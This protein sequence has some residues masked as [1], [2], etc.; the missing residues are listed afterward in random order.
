MNALPAKN[1]HDSRTD[2]RFATEVEIVCQPYGSIRTMRSVQGVILNFSRRGLYI[3]I[4]HAFKIGTILMVRTVGCQSSPSTT[5]YPEKPR[6][7]CLGEIKWRK[8]LG[9][10]EAPH[11]GMGLRYLD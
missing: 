11:Y 8:N 7:N 10:E 5:E 1:H 4:D 9:P 3:E 2:E 6:S